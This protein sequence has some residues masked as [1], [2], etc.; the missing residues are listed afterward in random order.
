[1]KQLDNHY[2]KNVTEK[3]TSLIPPATQYCYHCIDGL[4]RFVCPYW[5]YDAT[6]DDQECGYC[7]F[8][9]ESDWDNNENKKYTNA[10]TG[11]V[12]TANEIGM[13]MSL[14]W[15]LCKMCGQSTESDF[16][17]YEEFEKLSDDKKQQINEKYNKQLIEWAKKILPLINSEEHQKQ[18]EE[19]LIKQQ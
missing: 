11:E 5:D 16:D 14:L 13:P 9:E 10:K 2:Y 8:L 17:Y 19:W 3:D 15:D 18:L 1:M 6:K 7:H 12:Q 4:R